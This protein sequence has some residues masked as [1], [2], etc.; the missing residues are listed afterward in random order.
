M[1]TA[2]LTFPYHTQ[3]IGTAATT[4]ALS[5]RVLI[6]I[7]ELVVASTEAR[8]PTRSSL[9][10]DQG[11]ILTTRLARRR[12]YVCCRQLRTPTI[13]VHVRCRGPVFRS[14]F[15]LSRL[16]HHMYRFPT[17]TKGDLKDIRVQK[18][19]RLT[20]VHTNMPTGLTT[21]MLDRTA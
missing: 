9:R 16:L 5:I 6:T 13:I 11:G 8:S 7:E 3:T 10:F 20:M 17:R 19:A 1:T 15:V 2:D 14:K 4:H 21:L 18:L 12:K